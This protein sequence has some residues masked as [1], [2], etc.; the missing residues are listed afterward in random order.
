MNYFA[1]AKVLCKSIKQ[2][3]SD[4]KFLLAVS[5][6][7]PSEIDLAG[8][9]FDYIYSTRNLSNIDNIDIFYFKHNITE[10]CTAVKP[11]VAQYIFTTYGADKVV[12]LDPDTVVFDSL[13]K[14]ESYLDKYSMIFTP[15]QLVPE[16]QDIYVRENEILFLKRGTNNLGFFAV[17][18]DKEGLAFLKWWSD[19]LMHYCFDDSLGVLN[20]LRR[21][22]II[23]LFTDQKWIDLVPSFFNNYHFIKHPGYNVCTWNLSGRKIYFD[24]NKYYV[25]D[26]PLYF[27]HFSG[28][29]SGAHHSEL[30]KSLSFYPHNEDVKYL[31]DWYKKALEEN[32]EEKYKIMKYH[33]DAY[34]SGE[35]ISETDRKLL[36]IRKD[37]HH[38]VKDPFKKD[39]G[40]SF[41]HWVRKEY[42]QYY[43]E[44]YSESNSRNFKNKRLFLFFFPYDS[45]RRK[46]L[47]YIYKC[48]I[49]LSNR[50]FKKTSNYP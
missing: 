45:A 27:F 11:M 33:Y 23:G 38:L 5:D 18:N 8:E 46:L 19:R 50:N 4:I 21:D 44:R 47:R 35:K 12:Y 37:I 26:E 32:G 30:T 15:H 41:Y 2:F 40:F 22:G 6:M 43:E 28:F 17:K 1:K 29:D 20:E 13:A 9:L 42:P 3:N 14:M 34:S 31:S 10:L 49:I 25:N 16:E 7:I 39:E 36:H 24:G 48:F